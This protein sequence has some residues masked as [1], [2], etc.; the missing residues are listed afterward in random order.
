MLT[1]LRR[2]ALLAALTASAACASRGDV[3]EDAVGAPNPIVYFDNQ[4][5]FQANVYAITSSGSQQRIGTVQSGRREV[6][7]VPASAMG[8]DRNVAFAARL[9]ARGGRSPTSG[10]IG[11]QPGDVIE[12]V[13]SSDARTLTV[14]PVARRD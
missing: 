14:L 6:L 3:P 2:L 4:S 1:S 11:L 7:R 12:V 5:L 9:L 8:G 13:L 10:R